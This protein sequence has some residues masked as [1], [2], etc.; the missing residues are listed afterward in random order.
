VSGSF[1]HDAPY[2]GRYPHGLPLR[3]AAVWLGYC[4]L[5][6]CGITRLVPRIAHL[7]K[8]CLV[9]LIGCEAKPPPGAD[10]PPHPTIVVAEA[11]LHR[12]PGPRPAAD[13]PVAVSAG[14]L[15]LGSREDALPFEPTGAKL[16][17][18]AWR[19]WVYT[20]VGP[21]RTRYGYLRAGAIVD[22]R[23]PPIYNDGCK[24]GWY[25]INPR[26]FVCA[27][28]GATLE[29]DDPVVVASQRRAQRNAGLPYVYA[30]SDQRAPHLY[31]RLPSAAQIREVEGEYR[32]RAIR[33][34]EARQTRGE[35]ELI[36]YQPEPPQFLVGNALSK[37]YGLDTGLRR[38]VSA[39]QA[40][41]DSGFAIAN[42]FS[43]EGRVWGLT[44]ELDIIPMDRTSVVRPSELEGV[45]LEADEDLPVVLVSDGWLARYEPQE[46][47]ALKKVDGVPKRTL[48]AVAPQKKRIGGVGYW[49][50]SD[51]LLLP[52]AGVKVIEP[53]T[54][55]P[56]VATG[57][58]KWI[59]VSIRRQTLVAYEGKKAVFATLVS[60]GA[61]GLG[62]PEKVPST[63][64]GTFMIHAKHVSETMDGDDDK[65]D[66]FNL[67]DV[68]FVQYFHRG[69]ALH[70]TYWHDEFGRWRSHGCV[71]LSPKD[72]AWLFEWTDPHVP[73]AW[74]SVLNKERGT[75]VYVHP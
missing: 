27:G 43:W 46:N 40:S 3:A 34:L 57:T 22:R 63:I 25:R 75:V 17:S 28:K 26:G 15:E 60:T 13:Q 35:L 66:S 16:A 36:H 68:P 1:F 44:T 70:G 7:G 59:D 58:R 4:P 52:A 53:R 73:E 30:L 49:E 45:K 50:T 47:G 64:Q 41:S 24:D 67:R 20:D 2:P 32:G 9:G 29:L 19:T 56:S 12:Q 51:G 31:F 21:R 39:G 10:R 33:W 11:E 37:P 14:E 65:S 54:T 8:L 61:G 48:F 5:R 62:D 72:A 71:N 6:F 69:F 42:T 18:I 55:F 74:H 23:D 38:A